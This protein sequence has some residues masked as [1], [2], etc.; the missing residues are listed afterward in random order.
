MAARAELE[1]V[2]DC[3]NKPFMRSMDAATRKANAAG[4][5]IEKGFG[6]F[7]GMASAAG[8]AFAGAFAVGSVVS[9]GKS[10]VDLGGN[11]QDGA[12]K[13][14]L[15]TDALQGLGFAFSQSGASQEVFEKGMV[16]LNESI[17]DALSGNEKMLATFGRMGVLF[18]DL[19]SKAPDEILLMIA[20]AARESQNPTQ[21]LA[22]IMDLLGKSGQRMAAGLKQGSDGIKELSEQS[23]KF[24]AEEIRKLDELG[25]EWARLPQM[26]KVAMGKAALYFNKGLDD[27]GGG[28]PADF[29]PGQ[30]PNMTLF[31]GDTGFVP[32]EEVSPKPKGGRAREIFAEFQDRM[33]EAAEKEK[34]LAAENAQLAAEDLQ[35]RQDAWQ[36]IQDIN[37]ETYRI[38][39]DASRQLMDSTELLVSLER[40]KA[41][42]IQQAA[43]WERDRFQI[44]LKDAALARQEAARIQ[45]QINQVKV[46]GPKTAAQSMFSA[47]AEMMREDMMKSAG[48]GIFSGKSAPRQSNWVFNQP[49]GL[50]GSGGLQTGGLST[51]GLG[52]SAYGKI[53]RGDAARAKAGAGSGVDPIAAAIADNTAT[54]VQIWGGTGKR[55]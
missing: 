23:S 37:A 9:F 34:K 3:D 13:L 2:L 41:Q 49:V 51:G 32:P 16:K 26:I 14:N 46:N 4:K 21:T 1:A 29:A 43:R 30:K 10:I 47:R 53:R 24:T 33:E 15:T 54:M 25:D 35:R 52:G 22:D 5:N 31:P 18:S 45:A 36:E 42:L 48:L 39:L 12:D 38:E 50:Q 28:S 11:L 19:E 55:K 7:A 44:H 40:E 17:A 27:F 20:D 8:K 6:G